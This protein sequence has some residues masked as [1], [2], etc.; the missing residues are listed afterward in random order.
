MKEKKWKV[1]V[2]GG[3]FIAQGA[4]VI[5]RNFISTPERLCKMD[6][7][8]GGA[9]SGSV[10]SA[11]PFY[12]TIATQNATD[13]AECTALSALCFL[14][15]FGC[16]LKRLQRRVLQ[17]ET[18]ALEERKWLKLAQTILPRFRFWICQYP[19]FLA[20]AADQCAHVQSAP[21]RDKFVPALIQ[22]VICGEFFPVLET[23]DERIRHSPWICCLDSDMCAR[24]R[25]CVFFLL[26]ASHASA[27]CRS[28]DIP[29]DKNQERFAR[30]FVRKYRFSD[31]PILIKMAWKVVR[32]VLEI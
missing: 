10:S 1:V 21:D 12:K 29:F 16:P 20:T 9:S 26:N 27:V 2:L 31:D 13:Q 5:C 25:I 8:G 23:L 22:S 3:Q 28:F 17:N 24:H 32:L 4:D 19:H 7:S 15:L 14:H 30:M 18:L 6:S 11:E